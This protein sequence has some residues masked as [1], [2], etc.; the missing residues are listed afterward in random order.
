[1]RLPVG[2][3]L[4]GP[5]GAGKTMVAEMLVR[6]YGFTRVSLGGICRE[7]ARRRGLPQDRAT[8]QAMG[9]ALRGQEPAR[10]AILAWQGIRR[11][12]GPVVIDGV[13]LRAE[14]EW[15]SARGAWALPSSCRNLC[16]LPACRAATGVAP[17]AR[18]PPSGRRWRCRRTSRS[19]PP[20]NGCSL[21][22]ACG[23]LSGVPPS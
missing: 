20:R 23:Y 18:T 6:D 21:P 12:Q 14:A 5:A 8:L 22:T 13:R 11:A 10:V 3:Y 2:L 15:L 17:H 1:M 4:A 19:I 9:D 7:E 16:A